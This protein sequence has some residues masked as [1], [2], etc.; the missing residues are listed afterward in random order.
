MFSFNYMYMYYSSINTTNTLIGCIMTRV[1]KELVY[2]TT[3]DRVI[4]SLKYNKVKG[5]YTGH[6]CIN[7]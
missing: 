3:T 4:E 2:W 5:L 1:E 6:I 7:L